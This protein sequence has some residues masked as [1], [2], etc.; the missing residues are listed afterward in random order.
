[1]A[2]TGTCWLCLLLSKFV[3]YW[4]ETDGAAMQYIDNS[5][6]RQDSY[7]QFTS[8]EERWADAAYRYITQLD[9][10]DKLDAFFTTKRECK[11]LVTIQRHRMNVYLASGATVFGYKY[12]TFLPDEPLSRTES[13]DAVL[14]VDPYPLA[15]FGHLVL[16]FYIDYNVA[17]SDC[18]NMEGSNLGKYMYTLLVCTLMLKFSSK[19]RHS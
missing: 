18:H 4:S 9:C 16:V 10:E 1:M 14:V 19:T 5:S 13:H 6:E 17:P 3:M 2:K 15:N 12:K 8:Q 7:F 11:E